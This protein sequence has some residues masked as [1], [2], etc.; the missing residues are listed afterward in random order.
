M[1]TPLHTWH[2]VVKMHPLYVTVGLPLLGNNDA[3]GSAM[4]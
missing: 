2:K 1:Q 4:P 3:K